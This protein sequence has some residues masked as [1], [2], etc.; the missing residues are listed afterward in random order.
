[1]TTAQNN[2][3][4]QQK[5]Q[6]AQHNADTEIDNLTHLT[7]AQKSAEKALIN[8][9]TLAQKFKHNLMMLKL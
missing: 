4:G 6:E 1:M 8:N 9:K 2:L 5:L 7:P 3:H